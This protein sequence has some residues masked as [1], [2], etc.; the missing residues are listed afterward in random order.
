MSETDAGARNLLLVYHSKTGK[1]GKMAEAVRKGAEH[2]DI[3]VNVRY[4]HAFD[5]GPEDLLWA[6]GVIFGTP[7]NFGYMSGALKD[8]FDRT[9]YEVEGQVEGKPY[10]IFVGAGN[11]GTGAVT[12]IQRICNGYNFKEVQSPV[13]VAGDLQADSLD[14]CEQMGMAVAAG[15]E[16]G[17]Y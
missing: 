10:A 3:N 12:A 15:L 5:A 2:P 8:F 14:V 11:D 7:E 1:N 17:I 4:L 9:F 13:I 16:A 6:D